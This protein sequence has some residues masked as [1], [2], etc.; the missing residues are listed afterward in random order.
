MHVVSSSSLTLTLV[1]GAKWS[2]I[3]GKDK[4]LIFTATESGANLSMLLYQANDPAE[5]YSMSDSLKAQYTAYLSQGRVLMS[6]NGRVLAAITEDSVGWHDTICGCSA[7]AEIEE[8]Y[9]RTSY[10]EHRNNRLMN[11]RDN[12]LVELSKSGLGPRDLVPNVNL[13][14]KAV[15]DEAG[16]LQH[17]PDHCAAGATV[18]LRT[19]MDILLVLSNT[20]HPLDRSA[21]YPSVPITLEVR[22]AERTKV[23]DTWVEKRP[24][25]RRAYENTWLYNRLKS[26]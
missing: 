26:S 5:R 25:N 4:E 2:G 20:P 1:P 22:D 23:G 3:I 16:T 8:A 15:C 24:E 14:S 21:S 9:G 11:G 13:F 18:T 6:D 17:V 7:A 10:Q 19:E 12:F